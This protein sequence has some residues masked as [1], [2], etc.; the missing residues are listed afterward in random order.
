[1][2]RSDRVASAPPAALATRQV[3]GRF[4]VIAHAA[5]AG[6]A[7]L[8]LAVTLAL[9]VDARHPAGELPDRRGSSNAAVPRASLSVATVS[10]PASVSPAAAILPAAGMLGRGDTID[11]HPVLDA[12]FIER[13]EQLA[14]RIPPAVL[15][16][17]A[18]DPRVRYLAQAFTSGDDPGLTEGWFEDPAAALAFGCAMDDAASPGCGLGSTDSAL[19]PLSSG[20][21]A[22]DAPPFGRAP[23]GDVAPGWRCRPLG[24]AIGSPVFEPDRCEWPD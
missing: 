18:R 8:V 2:D 15:E 12:T 6:V 23:S 3:T 9:L 20:P 17:Q 24:V 4:A 7:L 14:A 22:M 1:M 11:G 10:P 16:G 13:M 21:A 19:A 5:S